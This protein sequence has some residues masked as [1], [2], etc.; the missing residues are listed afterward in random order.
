MNKLKEVR[1][2]VGMTQREL[3]ELSGIT[4]TTISKIE[5][6]RHAPRISTANEIAKIL[7]ADFKELWGI[8]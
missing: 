2:K 4:I 5:N 1:E 8:K 6:G 7:N 3:S